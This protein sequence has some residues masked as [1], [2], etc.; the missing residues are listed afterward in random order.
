MNQPVDILYHVAAVRDAGRVAARPGALALQGGRVVAA[1]H[2]SDPR[3]SRL[4]ARQTVELPQ[5]LLLPA[6]VNA[7]THLALTSL[8]P[9]PFTSKFTEWLGQVIREAPRDRQAIIDSVGRG[10]D[11]SV[12]AGV[13]YLGDIAGA[14]ELAFGARLLAEPMPGVSYLECFGHETPRAIQ[15]MEEAARKL[16]GE[17]VASGR[18]EVHWGITPHAPYSAGMRLYDAAARFSQISG[19]RLTTHLAETV[20][21]LQFVRDG[22]GPCAD[23]LH[24]LG[25]WDVSIKPTGLHPVDWV[26][27][28]LKNAHWLLAHCNYVEDSHIALLAKSRA[29]V[30]YCPLASEY[31]GHVAHRYRDMLE[32]GVNVCLGTDSILCQPPENTQP[33][34]IWPQMRRLFRRD[35]TDADT[36]LTMA[37]VNGMRGLELARI[38]ATFGSGSRSWLASVRIDPND[39]TDPL[40][41]ALENDYPLEPVPNE[42]T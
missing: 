24:D 23:L 10:I 42:E 26:A 37:T 9:R 32:A 35:G 12:R 39:V 31:F 36:L 28:L 25:K 19:C 20:E 34:G 11:L 33:L 6:L 40:T 3:L 38:D 21:E 41:Q 27:P 14:D 17:W 7:H 15:T 29:S 13:G 22:V 5:R 8:G 2:P 16:Q 30:V 1:G 18:D 4:R